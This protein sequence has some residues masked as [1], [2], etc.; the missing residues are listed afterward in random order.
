MKSNRSVCSQKLPPVRAFIDTFVPHW[1]NAPHS[2]N[3]EQEMFHEIRQ[4]MYRLKYKRNRVR[5]P[6]NFKMPHCVRIVEKSSSKN[7]SF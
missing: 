5:L 4:K 6:S 2:L 3:A 1:L 7:T